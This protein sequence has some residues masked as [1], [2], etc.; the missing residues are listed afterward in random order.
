MKKIYLLLI[1]GLSLTQSFGATI[2]SNNS[3][4]VLVGTVQ[5]EITALNGTTSPV[6]VD[7]GFGLQST[8]VINFTLDPD[9]MSYYLLDYDNSTVSE[10]LNLIMTFPLQQDLGIDPI[11]ITIDESGPILDAFLSSFIIPE[12][13][14]LGT[15]SA[16]AVGTVTQPGEAPQ[17]TIGNSFAETITT[18]DDPFAV[19]QITSVLFGSTVIS[20]GPLAGLAYENQNITIKTNV[21][22]NNNVQSVVPEPGTLGTLAFSFL[23]MIGSV[24]LFGRRK[25]HSA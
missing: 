2:I 17:V 20:S 21:N 23:F 3:D 18:V 22:S 1:T 7:L 11:A 5:D 6:L 25:L 10:H 8:G 4:F 14:E 15:I 12:N 24:Q 9:G 13:P 19:F 16:S